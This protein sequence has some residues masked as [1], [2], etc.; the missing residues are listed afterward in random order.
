[1]TTKCIGIIP[2]T[3]IAVLLDTVLYALAIIKA[4]F[5]YGYTNVFLFRYSK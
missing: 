1:M 2:S 4:I 3:T 5:L